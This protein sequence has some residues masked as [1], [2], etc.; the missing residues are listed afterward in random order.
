M[1][2]RFLL[3]NFGKLALSIFALYTVQTV[4]AMEDHHVIPLKELFLVAFILVVGIRLWAPG[5]SHPDC[6]CARRPDNQDVN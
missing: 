5:C 6:A 1:N 2:L 4:V 3:W